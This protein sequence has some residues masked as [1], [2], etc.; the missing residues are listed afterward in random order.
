LNQNY[1]NLEYIIIDGGSADR[2][3]DIIRK[4]EPYLAYWVSEK[5]RGQ[6]DAVNKGFRRATGDLLAWQNS[7]DLFLPGTLHR[8]ASLAKRHPRTDLFYSSMYIINADD[9]ITGSLRICPVNLRRFVSDGIFPFNQAAFYR[10]DI[11]GKIG[12]LDESFVFCM[13]CDFFIR[14][15]LDPAIQTRFSGGYWG[16]FRVHESSKTTTINEQSLLE[17]KSIQKKYGVERLGTRWNKTLSVAYR[18]ANYALHG[19]FEHLAYIFSAKM[20]RPR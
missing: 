13:D 9:Q 7:D 14:F 11:L 1:P 12:Y 8:A 3:A 5:D 19:D 15:F 2:S 10:R 17:G 20:R 4:Y 16:A 6:T 18:F